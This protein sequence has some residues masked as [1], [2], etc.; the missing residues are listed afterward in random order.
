MSAQPAAATPRRI[1]TGK[2]ASIA[3]RL[4]AAQLVIDTVLGDSSLQAIMA[5]YGYD[6]ARMREGQA[7]REQALALY[8]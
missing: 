6:A 2:G 5:A 4:V 3:A 1:S 7:L 8:Q